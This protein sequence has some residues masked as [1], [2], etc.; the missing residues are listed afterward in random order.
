VKASVLV[1]L[2]LA[3]PAWGADIPPATVVRFN[4]VC[5][6]CHEG[7][8]SGR[9]SFQSGMEAARHHLQRYLGQ[10]SE[11]ESVDLFALLKFTKEQ[12]RQY[13]LKANLPPD[14]HWKLEDL[15]TWRNPT[16]G[17]Y[18]VP[19]GELREGKYLLRLKFA[20]EPLGRVRIIGAKFDLAVD[21]QLCRG[22]T[23][24]LAFSVPGGEHYLHLQGQTELLGLELQ[25]QR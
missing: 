19:L 23:P 2:A 14:G 12:C 24:E 18:F 9:L 17:G 15:Q 1:S 7:E 4:T 10:L 16:E 11:R 22:S 8:C 13:P 25:R 6:N 3:L 20:G 5:A 21:Q